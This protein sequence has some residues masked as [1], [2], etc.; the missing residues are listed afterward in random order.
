VEHHA[1]SRFGLKRRRIKSSR[2][3]GEPRDDRT[4]AA[5]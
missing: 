3:L 5:R 4:P 2:W 1:I